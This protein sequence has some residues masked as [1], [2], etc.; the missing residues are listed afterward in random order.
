MM[1]STNNSDSLGQALACERKKSGIS[2]E[3]ISKRTNIQLKS[4]QA[5]E[6]DDHHLL[7]GTFYL[8]SYTKSY[9]KV[10]GCDENLF[11]ETH[12]KKV[13]NI[14]SST[15]ERKGNYYSRLRYSR[16]KKRNV[17]LSGIIF[18]TFFIGLF[19]LLYWGKD[20]VI[21]NSATSFVIPPTSL[22]S[23]STVNEFDI[24][25]WP[26]QV[27][28]EFL[29]DCWIQIHRGRENSQKKT[30]EQVFQKGDNIKINGYNLDFFI[31]NPSAIRLFLNGREITALK[32]RGRAERLTINPSSIKDIFEG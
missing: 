26:V 13:S 1:E 4:L 2:L 27:R 5:L 3:E 23:L 28:I 15:K 22:P 32:D 21:G 20:K 25:Y 6:N 30:V 14:K 12:K 31:G 11:W 19:I 17:F 10:I 9:L 24:D 7:P 8:K 16:F 29:D 18:F